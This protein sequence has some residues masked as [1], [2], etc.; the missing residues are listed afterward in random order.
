MYPILYPI[1][2]TQVNLRQIFVWIEIWPHTYA[3]YLQGEQPWRPATVA[4][5]PTVAWMGSL[6]LIFSFVIVDGIY[7]LEMGLGGR[8]TLESRV[9][10]FAIRVVELWRRFLYYCL[11]TL[12]CVNDERILV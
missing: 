2:R 12:A 9:A 6:Q 8:L 3:H 5:L 7:I 4:E 1:W 10:S 11:P